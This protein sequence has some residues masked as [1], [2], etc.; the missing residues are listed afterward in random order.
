MVTT[1]KIKNE[2][3]AARALIAQGASRADLEAFLDGYEWGPEF[4]A[5][6]GDGLIRDEAAFRAACTGY[7]ISLEHQDEVTLREEVLVVSD[8]LAI[9]SWQGDI[10][11]F[12]KN[13]D[14]MNLKNYGISLVFRRKGGRWKVIHSHES[15]LPPEI[16]G[17]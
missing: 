4:F 11:A 2:V 13:G 15:S 6:G 14:Q 16:L 3:R 1:D 5:I 12:F 10:K 17:R 8:D 7:Y 9:L